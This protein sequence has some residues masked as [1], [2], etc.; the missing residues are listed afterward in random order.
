[1]LLRFDSTGQMKTSLRYPHWG[2]P[3][4]IIRSTDGGFVMLSNGMDPVTKKNTR[5]IIVKTDRD[6]ETVNFP[7]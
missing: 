3:V 6:G 4:A 2:T 7:Y 5:P 1:M